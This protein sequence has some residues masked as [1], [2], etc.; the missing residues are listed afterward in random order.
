MQKSVSYGFLWG[1]KIETANAVTIFQNPSKMPYKIF[2]FLDPD[3]LL[4]YDT[5]VISPELPFILF[6]LLDKINGVYF[7]KQAL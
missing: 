4:W 1:D 7:L 2:F 5:V 6:W 3:L